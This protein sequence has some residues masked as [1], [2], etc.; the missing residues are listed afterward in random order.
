M[1]GAFSDAAPDRWGRGLIAKRA[2]KSGTKP[3]AVDYLLGVSDHSRQGALRFKRTQDGDFEFPAAD[4]PKVIELPEL[5][6][7]A[8]DITRDPDNQ[9]ALKRLLDAGTGSLGGAR[10]KASVRDDEQL[11]IAKFPNILSDEWDV[12]AWERTALDL[13]RMCGVTSPTT[14]LLQIDGRHVLLLDRFDRTAVGGRLPYV[15]AMTLVGGEDG[16]HNDYIDLVEAIEE[17]GSRVVKDL[18]ELWQ[19]VAVSVVIHNTDDHFRNHGFLRTTPAGWSLAPVFDINPNPDLQAERGT[20]IAGATHIDEEFD[21]LMELAVACRMTPAVAKKKLIGL[22]TI[23]LESWEATARA[24]SLGDS[25]L[26]RFAPIFDR[27][28]MFAE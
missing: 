26:A 2:A 7:A 28:R 1:P 13:A 25:E 18:V 6:R 19:R 12:M 11:K 16:Q 10:P 27:A 9:L 20:G 8:D 17:N 14:R 4:V 24:N 21:G 15:S 5:L 22:T 23:I 3:T